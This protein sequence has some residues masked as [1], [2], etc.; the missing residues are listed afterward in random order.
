[1]LVQLMDIGNQIDK[2]IMNHP[3]RTHRKRNWK[4]EKIALLSFFNY[5][6][7]RDPEESRK[8]DCFNSTTSRLSENTYRN[9]AHHSRGMK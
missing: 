7:D 3:S 4:R 8:Q 9:P 2:I 6:H 5:Q 1:M